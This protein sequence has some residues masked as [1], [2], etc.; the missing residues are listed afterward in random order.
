MFD[1]LAVY[2]VAESCPSVADRYTVIHGEAAY[3][4]SDNAIAPNGV[5][6]Y[7][8]DEVA[9]AGRAMG[10]RIRLVD[11][12]RDVLVAIIRRLVDE[13]PFE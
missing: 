13:T 3:T 11:L 8:T 1:T 9:A 4:M 6:M 2:D 7:C 12:P 10:V 5:N